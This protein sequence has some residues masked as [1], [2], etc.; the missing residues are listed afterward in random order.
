MEGLG[1]KWQ[2]GVE[3]EGECLVCGA[4]LAQREPMQPAWTQ[5]DQHLRLLNGR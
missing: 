2:E 5:A 1:R 4:L 3:G